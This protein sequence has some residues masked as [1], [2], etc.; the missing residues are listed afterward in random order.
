ME[1]KE[2]R[3]GVCWLFN[4]SGLENIILLGGAGVVWRWW[5]TD[6]EKCAE[7]GEEIQK[8]EA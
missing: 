4:G 2:W 5:L 6:P 3:K 8:E 1:W 7:G